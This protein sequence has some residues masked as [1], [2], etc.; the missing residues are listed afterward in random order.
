MGILSAKQLILKKKETESPREVKIRE[1]AEK[2]ERGE[3]I[4]NTNVVADKL[5]ASGVLSI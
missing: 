2:L 4:V 1:L 3:Y 5:L